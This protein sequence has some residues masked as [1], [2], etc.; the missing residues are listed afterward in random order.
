MTEA[1]HWHEGRRD[2]DAASLIDFWLHFEGKLPLMAHG[3]G[4]YL[5][6]EFNEPY[7][8]YDMQEHG[9]T[10]V[11][12]VQALDLLAAFVGQRLLDG[13]LIQGYASEPSVGGLRLRFE[14]GVLVVA[15]L[16]DEWVL[17]TGSIPT[18]LSPYLH[19]GSWLGGTSAEQPPEQPSQRT[20]ADIDGAQ[21]QVNEDH[22]DQQAATDSQCVGQ[23]PTRMRSAAYRSREPSARTISR[24]G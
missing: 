21:A 22:G 11:E 3:T 9:E 7:A 20:T 19:A 4:E 5:L 2:G 24:H 18:E 23:R 1:R 10:R 6:L 16:A 13:A 12:P 17:S 14:R 8:S 15:S